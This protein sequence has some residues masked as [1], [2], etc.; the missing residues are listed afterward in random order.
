MCT[1]TYIIQGCV[2]G[3]GIILKHWRKFGLYLTTTEN[4]K[5]EPYAYRIRC[6]LCNY[7]HGPNAVSRYTLHLMQ[8]FLFII[9]IAM[10]YEQRL[11]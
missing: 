9:P 6:I 10:L 5:L 1:F 8:G 7:N 2:T 3:T 4:D 11:A